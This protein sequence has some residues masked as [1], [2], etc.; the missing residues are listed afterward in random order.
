MSTRVQR[1]GG[2]VH[3]GTTRFNLWAP[4]AGEVAVDIRGME[5]FLMQSQGDG[6]FCVHVPCSAGAEYCF[7]IDNARRVPDPAA[8]AQAEDVHG[9]SRV[10]DHNT[11]KWKCNDWLGNPWHQTI[12]YEL[13]VGLMGGF[14]NVEKRLPALAGMGITAIE[15]M[16]LHQFPGTRNWGYDG[17]LLFAPANIY[18]S[19]DDLK[20]LIDTAHSLGLSIFVDVVY[21]HF[22]PDGNYL[23]LYASPFFR[24][25]Q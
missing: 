12:I 9:Y 23:N 6:W 14:K 18:G 11:F 22:G 8:H 13:H 17:A 7:I 25:D 16:P 5:T 1:H 21:N 2:V 3:N 20:S 10:V 24:M 15:L 4:D 19:P